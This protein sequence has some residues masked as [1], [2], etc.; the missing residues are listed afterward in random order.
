VAIQTYATDNYGYFF[1]NTG[2]YALDQMTPGTF[3]N[4]ARIYLYGR[5]VKP[6]GPTQH[7]SKNDVL[8]CPT[9]LYGRKS[10]VP[11]NGQII[12]Y[13]YLPGRSAV[14]DPNYSNVIPGTGSNL[15]GWFTREKLNGPY[16]E[17]PVMMDELTYNTSWGCAAFQLPYS[18]HASGESWIPDGGNFLYEDG[19]VEW[20]NFKWDGTMG[21]WAPGSQI[22]LGF[23]YPGAWQEYIWPA[24]LTAGP[25]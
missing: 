13:F 8:F 11:G 10:T 22:K 14:T 20:L 2:W 17:A 1:D 18:N 16:R 25:W 7:D 23:Y 21:G 4:F 3:T 6:V 15:R 5:A 9:A 24:K 19:H 12:G